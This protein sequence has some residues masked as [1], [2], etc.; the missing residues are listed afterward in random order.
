MV[1][2]RII[3]IETSGLPKLLYDPIF[4]YLTTP[5]FSSKGHP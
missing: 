4:I 2:I 5:K 3:K 1:F